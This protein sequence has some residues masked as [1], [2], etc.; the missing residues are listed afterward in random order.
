MANT[1]M[2]NQ[3]GLI[4]QKSVRVSGGFTIVEV[5]LFLALTG[6]L[7]LAAMAGVNA[8]INN[9]RFNDAIRSSV[10]Y[11]QGQY[12]Q[13]SNGRNDRDAA[14]SCDSA[15][16]L[17]TGTTPPG[18][19]DCAV[20]GRF[21]K[22]EG[23]EFTARY[24]LGYSPVPLSQLTQEDTAA[25]AQMTIVVA[26]DH[27]PASSFQVPWSIAVTGSSV[28]STSP[29]GLAIIRSPVSGNV[30]YYTFPTS[31]GTPSP[32]NVQSSLTLA[33]RNRQVTV[34]FEGE[35]LIGRRG[36][37]V[38]DAGKGQD[39]ISADLSTGAGAC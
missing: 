30:M 17:G 16:N 34:C 9:T 31:S 2:G 8:N 33:N 27:A 10:S 5:I 35:G 36:N 38:F 20:L 18:M 14:L 3:G 32:N 39:V 28:S 15:L 13:V 29:L 24:I 21:I 6:L 26:D 1:D 19:T 22:L 7:L 25:L 4:R 11:L 23:S 37:V 12:D